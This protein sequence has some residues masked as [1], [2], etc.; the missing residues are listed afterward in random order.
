MAQTEKQKHIRN[1][2]II[3]HIPHGKGTFGSLFFYP[4]GEICGEFCYLC[5]ESPLD[6]RGICAIIAIWDMSVQG[7]AHREKQALG[8]FPRGERVPPCRI[9]RLYNSI[10]IE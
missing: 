1:F 8:L 2:S 6:R 7:T 4:V 3:A 5:A 9:K 10:L